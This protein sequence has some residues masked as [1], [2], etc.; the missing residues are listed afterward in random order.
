MANLYKTERL[1][2]LKKMLDFDNRPNPD[3]VG[4]MGIKN[5]RDREILPPPI[6]I[7]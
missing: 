1:E 2:Q 4:Y 5:F 7:K 6:E 3:S